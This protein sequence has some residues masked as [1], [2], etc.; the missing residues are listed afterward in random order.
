MSKW[1]RSTDSLLKRFKRNEG[2]FFQIRR[3]AG[4]VSRVRKRKLGLGPLNGPL[5]MQEE[6]ELPLLALHGQCLPSPADR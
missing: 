5:A 4:R 2:F 3:S 1:V 6:L